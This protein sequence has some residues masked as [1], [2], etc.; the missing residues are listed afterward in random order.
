M[1]IPGTQ[2]LWSDHSV[3][4]I[5]VQGAQGS[6]FHLPGEVKDSAQLR[7]ALGQGI[8]YLAESRGVRDVAALNSDAHTSC[9][10]PRKG[11]TLRLVFDTAPSAY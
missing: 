5:E 11:G 4:S 7:A 10:Q 2:E 9:L 3:Q 6:I 8:D 1:Q